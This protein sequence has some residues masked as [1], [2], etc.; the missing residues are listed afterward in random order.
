MRKSR[1]TEDQIIAILKQ[2]MAGAQPADL[3]RR[4]RI[5]ETTLYRW[6]ARFGDTHRSDAMQLRQLED[7]NQRLERL[8]TD[9][10]LER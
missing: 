1:F 10:R 7:D 3:C 9:L 2:T 5:T 6:K 4:H 8:A